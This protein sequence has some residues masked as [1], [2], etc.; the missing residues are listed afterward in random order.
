MLPIARCCLFAA[1]LSALPAAAADH[2]PQ[3]DAATRARILELREAAWRAWFGNDREAFEAVVPDELVALGWGGGA[4]QDR[5]G[6]LAQMADFA[7]DGGRLLELEFPQDLFQQYGDVVV[8]YTRYR[9]VLADKAGA[10]SETRGRGTEIFVR[11]RGR[12]IHTGWH[13]DTV[14]DA[15]MPR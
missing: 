12:W 5:A 9:A 2:G 15:P 4:W 1:L 14:D 7:R 13:L 6:T 3:P 8:L 10:R 11:R